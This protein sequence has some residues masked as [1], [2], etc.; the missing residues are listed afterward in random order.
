MK[1]LLI[2]TAILLLLPFTVTIKA[3][4]HAPLKAVIMGTALVDDGFDADTWA[5]GVKVGTMV[6]IDESKGLYLRTMFTRSA[7]G[8]SQSDVQSISTAVL[9]DWFLGKEFGF[10][11][12]LGGESYISGDFTGTDGFAGFGLTRSLWSSDDPAYKVPPQVD[13][14]VEAMVQ[15]GDSKQMGSLMQF[16][17]GL[18]L[19]KSVK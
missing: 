10:Y 15:D 4:T 2:L 3:G 5:G 6:S 9:M 11:M 12:T 1:R 16:N 17:I 18:T 19:T 13:I 8:P 7:F 14:F